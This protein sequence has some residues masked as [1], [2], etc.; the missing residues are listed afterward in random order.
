MLIPGEDMPFS[1]SGV[2]PDLIFSPHSVPSRMTI[3]HL[4]E[5]LAGKVAALRGEI[6][7][8]TAFDSEK[9]ENLRKELEVKKDIWREQKHTI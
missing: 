9:E 6:V 7:D 5:A 4:L 2:V 3:G 8:G 1:S